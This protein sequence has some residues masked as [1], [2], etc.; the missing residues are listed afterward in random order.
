MK[1]KHRLIDCLQFKDKSVEERIDFAT[2]EKLCK[3]CFSKGHTTKDC[4]L[5]LKCRANDRDKKY[6]TL[7][8]RQDQQQISINSSISHKKTNL[9]KTTTFLQVLP[10]EVSNGSQTLEV[11][12]L[13]DAGSDTTIINLK[14]GR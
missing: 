12:S 2:K 6:Y 11:N 13:P 9:P 3:N 14:V 4:I 7:F 1:T 8:H 10:V 5:K